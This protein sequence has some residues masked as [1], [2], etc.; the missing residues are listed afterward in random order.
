MKR[1]FLSNRVRSL[2][3]PGNVLLVIGLLG[4]LLGLWT[5]R[6]GAQDAETKREKAAAENSSKLKIA[7][8]APPVEIKRASNGNSLP[9]VPEPKQRGGEPES[10]VQVANLVYAGV[11][12]SHCFSDHFLVT[13]EK[14]S[15]ISTS[16]RFHAVKSSSDELFNFP[17]VIMTGEG[18]FSLT[19]QER[20]NLSQ[21]YTQGWIS[22]RIGRLLVQG[23]ESLVSEGNVDP[24]P[25]ASARTA[26]D[27]PSDFQHRV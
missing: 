8:T 11:K 6:I 9:M 21:Y 23:V 17:M 5:V 1:S 27:G 4:V 12:S 25:A 7:R 26:R 15:A 24:L 16:R 10:I 18:S 3:P 2:F 20:K 14:E 13:A 22:A 19:D